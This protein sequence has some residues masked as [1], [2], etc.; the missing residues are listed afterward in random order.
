MRI[1]YGIQGT[2]NGHITRA[3]V[4]ATTFN[5]LGVD[6]DYVFSGRREH[7]YFDMDEFANYR[8]FRGLSFTSKSGQVDSLKT[9]KN[10]R[11]LQLIKDIKSL[12]L[13]H[14]DLVF[15]DFEPITA[16]AA[17]QQGVPV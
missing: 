16:W 11:P 9:L 7:D 14:Y 15:N 5:A 13:R 8:A 2:G 3:R 17:K 4:M 12:D 10:A 6:V 1:L